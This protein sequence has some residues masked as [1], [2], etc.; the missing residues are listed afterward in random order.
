MAFGDSCTIF[1]CIASLVAS[2]LTLLRVVF[3]RYTTESK[4]IGSSGTSGRHEPVAEKFPVGEDGE[5][6]RVRHS[7]YMYQRD[8]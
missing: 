7:E 8:E 6:P 5:A 2:G 4:G 1:I 3:C